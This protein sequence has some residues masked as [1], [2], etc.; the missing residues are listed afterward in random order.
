M[1]WA[2]LILILFYQKT[3]SFD[4]GPLRRLFP[5]GYCRFYPSCSMY[6]YEAI[7][8]YGFLKGFW[9]AILRI[10]R[11]NPWNPGGT[12]PVPCKEKHPQ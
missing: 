4:H 8:S 9:L 12:D 10:L 7:K 11:C 3:L 6:G 2:A 1:K 5:Y